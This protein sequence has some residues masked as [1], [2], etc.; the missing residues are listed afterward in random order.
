[1]NKNVILLKFYYDFI[2]SIHENKNTSDFF[3]K[4]VLL[5]MLLGHEFNDKTLASI[6]LYDYLMITSSNSKLFNDI[7]SCYYL[8]LLNDTGSLRKNRQLLESILATDIDGILFSLHKP[9]VLNALFKI[10]KLSNVERNGW[11]KR[12][13]LDTYWENDVIHTVQMFALASTYFRLFNPS[14]L[15]YLKIMEM[16]LIHEVGELESGDIVEGDVLHD[17]KHDIERIAVTAVFSPLHTGDYFIDLWD[18]F[19][20]R[21]SREALFVY[22]LDKLDPVLKAH[23]LDE[24]LNRDDLFLEFYEFEEKR[25]TF[26]QGEFSDIFKKIKN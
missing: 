7:D 21:E 23:F 9:D 16:I 1:M 3:F 6:E 13:V 19:E 26:E 2:K 20:K 17:S 8:N 25:G 22:Y 15:N 10:V 18:E 24:V 11:I 5:A 14:D 12:R 4:R